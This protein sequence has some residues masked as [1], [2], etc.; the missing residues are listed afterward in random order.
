MELRMVTQPQSIGMLS[1]IS[2]LD[3]TDEKGAYCGQ[4]LGC[5]GADVIK[6]EKPGG[7]QARNLGP[8]VRDIPRPEGSL[9][10]LAFNTNKR[11]ITLN[12]E[13]KEG[14]G[15]FKRLV[16]KADVVI[17]SYYPGYMEE[18]GLG[19]SKLETVNP[20]I[21]VA[22]ITPY[23]QEGPYRDYK[24]SDLDCWGMG[25]LLANT[26]CPNKPLSYISHIPAS[27]LIAS[28]D[29]ALGI[30]LALFW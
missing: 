29:A 13:N 28:Q 7:D 18:L 15:I 27:F 14:K 19:Y 20:G 21:I 2:V 23:G 26:G 8:F 6:I 12:I 17:E 30:A 5:L 9:F 22:S 4:L 16:K 25:G 11:G 10:W 3:L 24:A 1:H